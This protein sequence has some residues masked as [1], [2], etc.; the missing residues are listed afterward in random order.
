MGAA[1]AGGSRRSVAARRRLVQSG[2]RRSG[3]RRRRTPGTARPRP[4]VAV[5]R[6]RHAGA[7]RGRGR[8]MN[9]RLRGWL[10]LAGAILTEV[11]GTLSLR[12]A[13]DHPGLYVIVVIGF[14][15]AFVFLAATLREGIPL[16]VAY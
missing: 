8:R 3:G 12:G 6:A 14:T 16:G 11:S 9:R 5:G 13:L 15:A 7:R 10:Y 4:R 1:T 2:A